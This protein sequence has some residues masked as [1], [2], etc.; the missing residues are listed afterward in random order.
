MSTW[1]PWRDH[2]EDLALSRLV[3]VGTV[4]RTIW[5]RVSELHEPEEGDGFWSLSCRAF[6]RSGFQLIRRQQD[7][8]WLTVSQEQSMQWL[9]CFGVMPVRFYH[10]DS[11]EVP[12]RYA[13]PLEIEKALRQAVLNL[14]DRI[15]DG[16]LLRIVTETDNAG[17]PTAVRLLKC[18]E[19]SGA[20][21]SSFTIPEAAENTTIIEFP[22]VEPKPGVIPPK[23]TA[24]P[25]FGRAKNQG[26]NDKPDT[27]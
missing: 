8:P 15:R 26:D 16:E 25:L 24:R 17:V 1:L 19:L 2:H 21:I 9:I 18:E 27:K 20:V 10:G 7:W 3:S 5:R 11:Q 13:E 14:D 12:T 4:L 6:Q 22:T 23:P